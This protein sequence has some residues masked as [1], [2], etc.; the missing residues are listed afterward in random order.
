MSYINTISEFL[1]QA[2]TDYRIFDMGRAI[3]NM[4]TQDFL[5]FENTQV[6]APCPRQQHAW[7]GIVF[8]NPELNESHY[9]WFIKLPLDEQGRLITAA[10]N[11]FL[12][13]VVEA[14]GNQLQDKQKMKQG[15]P[16]NPYTFTPNQ[17][18]L[19]DFNSISRK[20]LSLSLSHYQQDVI[21]YLREPHSERWQHLSLQG[22]ADVAASIDRPEI[23]SL[24]LVN[25][26]LLNQQVQAALC[27]SFENSSLDVEMSNMLYHWFEEKSDCDERLTLTLR[28]LSQ[29]TEIQVVNKIVSKVLH[30]SQT[31]SQDV[32]IL[33]AARHWNR[34][35][36][37][38]TMD[39]FIQH[40]VTTDEML[41]VGLFSDLVQIPSIRQTCMQ[42]LR[43]TNKSPQ[44][45][46]AIS[47]LFKSEKA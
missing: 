36:E 6:A 2:G 37:Q 26:T 33:I 3:R 32:L 46:K 4:S 28:A 7:F 11:Q 19:A 21:E 13:I 31:V 29:S 8:Y 15:L 9:I 25:F 45:D 23:K 44:L 39:A 42:V 43:A 16:D 22:I 12:Q 5:D 17:Q 24:I 30:K 1:L 47:R 14:L 20:N 27:R 10:R 35:Q 40:L 34:L 18:Q 38:A 41:F